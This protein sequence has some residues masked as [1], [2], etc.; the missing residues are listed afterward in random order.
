MN[1]IVKVKTTNI[2]SSSVNLKTKNRL[3]TIDYFNLFW[4]KTGYVNKPWGDTPHYGDG[5]KEETGG[6]KERVETVD[7]HGNENELVPTYQ[8]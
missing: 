3:F 4:Y 8:N 5:S 7:R 1:V 6:R 2:T